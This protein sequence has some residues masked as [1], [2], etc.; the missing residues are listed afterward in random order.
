MN[1]AMATLA[2]KLNI[3]HSRLPR[4]EMAVEVSEKAL[5]YITQLEELLEPE[6]FENQSC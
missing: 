6:R 2:E 5:A 1:K 4:E 3:D